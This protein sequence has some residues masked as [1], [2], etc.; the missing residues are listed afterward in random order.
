MEMEIALAILLVILALNLSVM[1]LYRH[2]KEKA[3]SGGWR[4]SEGT[5]LLAALVAPFG[6]AY[7]MRRYRHKTRKAK[8]L[9]VY[10]FMLL[11]LAI[12]AYLAYLLMG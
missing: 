4:T 6:A 12:I 7:G 8:F 2:D 5:L 9:L 1:L 11:H 10:V 3:R